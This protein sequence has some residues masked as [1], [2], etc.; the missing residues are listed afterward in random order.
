LVQTTEIVRT[1]AELKLTVTVS[2]LPP[3]TMVVL[4]PAVQAKV[5][6]VVGQLAEKV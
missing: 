2:V 5:G 6:E 3:E 1:P 4:A